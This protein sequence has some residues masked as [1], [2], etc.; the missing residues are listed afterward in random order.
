[1]IDEKG[2]Q[3]AAARHGADH[4]AVVEVSRIPFRPEFRAACEMN[5][6]GKYGR[7]WTCP[8]DVGPIEPM[9]ELAKGFEHAFVFQTIGQLEDSFDIE[10]MEDAAKHHNKVAQAL[11]DEVVPQLESPLLMGAGACHVCET[12]SK[13]DNEPCRFPARA[14]ASLEAYGIAV[15]ELA[16][17]CGLNYI[18]G[19][20]TVTFFGTI[21]Y[22]RKEGAA[23]A[24]S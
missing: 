15:S 19:T 24:Q 10:G 16:A 22:G 6:C 8:P 23:D 7:C 12:C 17:I 1:M 20:N 5:S 2:L 18:N 3:E 9:I 4:S 14:I 21:L 13:I 11:A